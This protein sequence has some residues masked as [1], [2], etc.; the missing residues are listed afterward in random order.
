MGAGFF[1][2]TSQGQIWMFEYWFT[3]IAIKT[4]AIRKTGYALDLRAVIV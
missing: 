1:S 3:A 2:Y 4:A